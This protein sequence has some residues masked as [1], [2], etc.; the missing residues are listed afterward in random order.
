MGIIIYTKE[1]TDPSLQK[2]IIDEAMDGEISWES[3]VRIIFFFCVK[4]FC[5][6]LASLMSSLVCK[7]ICSNEHT[8]WFLHCRSTQFWMWPISRKLKL[9]LT[10]DPINR[11]CAR[12]WS[13]EIN[14]PEHMR[15]HRFIRAWLELQIRKELLREKAIYCQGFYTTLCV[16]VFE[17]PCHW[18]REMTQ[19]TI[20]NNLQ[21]C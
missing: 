18:P 15:S 16:S 4:S 21:P 13:R 1:C 5:M 14:C 10:N 7:I 8:G 6:K 2:S 20:C 3:G 9:L 11:R 12:Q 19:H 17:P